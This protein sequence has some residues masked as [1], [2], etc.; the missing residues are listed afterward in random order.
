MLGDDCLRLY[1][2]R[3]GLVLFLIILV[4]FGTQLVSGQQNVVPTVGFEFSFPGSQPDQYNFSIPRSGQATYESDGKLSPDAEPTDYRVEFPIS[5]S[6]RGRI[7]NLAEKVNYFQRE[8]DARKKGIA[9]TGVK[10]LIYK[11]TQH[12]VKATYNYSQIAAVQ[13]LTE[14]FQN[15]A[16]TMEFGRRLAYYHHYQKLA[17]D[18]ELKRMDEMAQAHNLGELS[19]IAP[20]LKQIAEDSSVI[21]PVRARAQRMLLRAEASR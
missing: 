9:S 15:M 19:A 5:E 4:F 20:V 6:T 17:L 3:I 18:E 11:D 8:L 21:N 12:D 7:F 10:T 1:P 16:A 13:Q 14:I 2:R